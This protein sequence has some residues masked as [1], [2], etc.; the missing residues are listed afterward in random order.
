L[1]TLT[2]FQTPGGLE[3]SAQKIEVLP[4]SSSNLDSSTTTPEVVDERI[5][6]CPNGLNAMQYSDG[7]PLMCLPGRSQCPEKSVCYYN[8][9]DFFCCPNEDD[10]Y[11]VH[12]FGGYDG[13]EVKHGYKNFP[14]SL[15]IKSIRRS[16]RENGSSRREQH[17]P[18]RVDGE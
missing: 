6:Q 17:V 2:P 15:N 16:K 11:D 18:T 9:I 10:P 12:I 3:S 8:G 1:K 7:R 5:P 14:S 13:E 4:S